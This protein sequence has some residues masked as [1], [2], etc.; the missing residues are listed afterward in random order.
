MHPLIAEAARRHEKLE[1]IH[2]DYYEFLRLVHSGI[3]SAETALT[4]EDRADLIFHLKH[5]FDMF[6]DLKKETNVDREMLNN[7]L[8]TIFVTRANKKDKNVK[9]E[10]ATVTP[11]MK[12]APKI[13]SPNKEPTKFGEL[14]KA[15]GVTNPEVIERGILRPHW[16][17]LTEW[18]S[19]CAEQ[20]KPMPGGIDPSD[21]S[22]LFETT[23]R[24]RT[25]VDLE[26][27]RKRAAGS[28][29]EEA[30]SREDF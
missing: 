8:C 27:Y 6:E 30:P 9:G 7:I 11:R 29:S 18:C 28:L 2:K 3:R 15:L 14:L 5:M 20:G 1:E 19:E 10:I 25:D 13:P 26:E 22:A 4:Q 21:T 12:L 17:S 16:P 23:V 24:K